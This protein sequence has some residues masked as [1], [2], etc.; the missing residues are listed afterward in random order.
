MQVRQG[1]EGKPGR[2][3]R[4]GN[5]RHSGWARQGSVYRAGDSGQA[6]QAGSAVL[7]VQRRQGRPDIPS[8][9]GRAGKSSMVGKDR[10]CR[11]GQGRHD[12]LIKG[13]AVQ[14]R[15]AC[16]AGQGRQG[17]SRRQRKARRAG[18]V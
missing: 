3:G 10:E 12:I 18:Q 1:R 9:W 6:Y 5:V 15:P 11:A 7:A 2:Q 14:N 4:T 13:R 8:S 16:Q 17:I